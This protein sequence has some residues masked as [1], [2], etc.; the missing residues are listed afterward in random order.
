MR[1]QCGAASPAEQG[2]KFGDDASAAD[3]DEMHNI[4]NFMTKLHDNIPHKN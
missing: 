4:T 1:F 2:M 3:D